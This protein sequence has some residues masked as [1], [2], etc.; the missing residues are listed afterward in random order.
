MHAVIQQSSSAVHIIA[1]L[2]KP[3]EL[4]RRRW[5]LSA[6]L[7]PKALAPFH[8]LLAVCLQ[9]RCPNLPLP[10]DSHTSVTHL[11]FPLRAGRQSPQIAPLARLPR[12]LNL[13]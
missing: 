6:P 13:W 4:G 7:T 9:F 11:V 2:E 3:N 1:A 10:V 8:R 5:S 12:T